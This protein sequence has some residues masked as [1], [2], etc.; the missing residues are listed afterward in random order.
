MVRMTE[1]MA[2]DVLKW[3]M[4]LAILVASFATATYKVYLGLDFPDTPICQAFGESM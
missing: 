1:Y 2:K 3:L 4:L